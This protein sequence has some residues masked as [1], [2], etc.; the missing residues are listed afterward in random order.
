[1]TEDAMHR[2]EVREADITT[3]DVDAIV[4]AIESHTGSGAELLL[5][6]AILYPGGRAPSDDAQIAV[7]V[8]GPAEPVLIRQKKKIAGMWVNEL[9]DRKV[10]WRRIVVE[11]RGGARV[12]EVR[13]DLPRTNIAG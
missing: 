4:N 8:K 11:T 10:L 1:M 12:F 7:V 3:L 2:I 13:G 6:G 5:F 9:T